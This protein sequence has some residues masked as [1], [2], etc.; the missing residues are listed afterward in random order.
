MPPKRKAKISAPPPAITPRKTRSATAVKRADTP[1]VAP[2]RAPSKKARL[3][4]AGNA[5]ETDGA[6]KKADS[7]KAKD[8]ASSAAEALAAPPHAAA[9]S[10]GSAMTIIIE[11]WCFTCI[12][13]SSLHFSKQCTSFKTRAIKVKDG[14]ESAV[15]GIVVAVNPDKVSFFWSLH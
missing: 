9:A 4:T 14:L 6:K 10:V 3:S 11:A 1:V 12:D 15:P 8:D 5:E 13:S 2:A 7:V